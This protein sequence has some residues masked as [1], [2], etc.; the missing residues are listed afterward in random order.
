M[1]KCPYKYKITNLQFNC[2]YLFYKIL[3]VSKKLTYNIS[4]P[5]EYI[6]HKTQIKEKKQYSQLID[7][8]IFY[9]IMLSNIL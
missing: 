8:G 9:N 3:I 6:I 1:F 7:T 5:N 2:L 4:I